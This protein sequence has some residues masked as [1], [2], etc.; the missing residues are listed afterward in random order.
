MW[1]NILVVYFC[2]NNIISN[3]IDKWFA[4]H[5]WCIQTFTLDNFVTAIDVIN[6][7]YLLKSHLYS[8]CH[9][10]SENL[11]CCV[12]E[13]QSCLLTLLNPFHSLLVQ[14]V[15]VQNELSQQSSWLWARWSGLNSWQAIASDHRWGPIQFPAQW[16]LKICHYSWNNL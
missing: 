8:T 3:C 16:N 4:I 6:I 7:F 15:F 10:K 5:V 9:W 14:S 11:L 12:S 1:K 2:L 13:Q